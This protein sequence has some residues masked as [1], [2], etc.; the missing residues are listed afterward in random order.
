MRR[1]A[2]LGVL[3]GPKGRGSNLRAIDSA[4]RAGLLDA[5]VRIVVSPNDD[6]PALVYAREQG[7]TMAIVPPNGRYGDRLV[8]ALDGC[9]LVCLA[10]YLRLLPQEVLDRFP[11][12]VLNVHPSL[13]PKFGGAGMYGRRVHEAVLASGDEESG[14]TVHLVDSRYDEGRILVQNRC[15]VLDIDTVESLAE[16]VL[17]LEHEA[18]I[19]AIARV[20]DER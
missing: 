12:R 19:E 16:K 4:C 8:Q 3:I 11:K 2:Q 7:V 15:S 6:A 1:P 18:Y 13:L 20:L 5:Q 17:E 14:C 9:D 10:G